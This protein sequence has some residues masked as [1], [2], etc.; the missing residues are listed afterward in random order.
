MQSP[1]DEEALQDFIHLDVWAVLEGWLKELK[2][3][4]KHLTEI[5]TRD[6]I[7]AHTK[8]D[9]KQIEKDV[10]CFIPITFT[11]GDMTRLY[12]D[13]RRSQLVITDHASFLQIARRAAGVIQD[14]GV[15][16]GTIIIAKR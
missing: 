5:F 10:F 8:A 13:F 7:A 15:K 16:T 9:T 4:N 1:L 14:R 6:E 11:P 3:L 2:T 12:Q